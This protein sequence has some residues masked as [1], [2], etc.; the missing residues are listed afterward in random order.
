MASVKDHYNNLLVPYYS[1]ICGGS[2]LKFEENRKIFQSH[3]IRPALSGVAVDLGA[4]SGFQSIPLS[5]S[6]F[7]VI[8]I[9]W[10]HD[11][12]M[13]LKA[14]AEGLSIQTIEDNLLNFSEHIPKN[15]ELIVCMGDTLTHLQT[16]DEVKILL[17]DACQALEYNGR[18]ILGFR[19][20]T[21]ELKDL[22]RFIPVRS[23]FKN[24]FTCFLEYEKDHVRVYDIIHE[25][26]GN[27]WVMRKSY[28]R[29]L[30]IS[31]QWMNDCLLKTGFTIENSDI[32]NGMVTIIACKLRCL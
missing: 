8:A 19:D 28:F 12:L 1:W 18:L 32:D 3:G 2:E 24:I 7:K 10:C 17:G 22:D 26:T 20:L 9:D 6:G 11:L 13:E 5:N 14:H 29:K 23:D 15:I 27:Q 16:L 30:R 25:R 21:A 4:G 31:P